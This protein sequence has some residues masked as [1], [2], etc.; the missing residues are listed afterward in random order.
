M[1][2]L[3]IVNRV[4][5]NCGVSGPALTTVVGQSGESLNIINWTN[6]AWMDIQTQ[7]EDWEWMRK[8]ATFPTVTG[9]P[10]YTIAQIGLTDFGAWARDTFR[11]YDSTVGTNSEIFMEYLDYDAW[12]DSYQFGALRQTQTRPLVMTI[13]PDK[14]I[15]LGPFPISGYTILGD[16]YSVP[17]EMSADTDIPALPPRFHLAIIYR[18]MMAYGSY[19]NAPE[20]YT[21]GANEFDRWMK[22][23][24]ANQMPEILVPGALC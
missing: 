12:R 21:R 8:T 18:A 13:A 10:L 14:S 5:T 7:R 9:Q 24:Y 23:I 15:G 19:E 2:F 22:R 17:T 6:E 20:V 16:Y 1:N 11:N 3:A 4:R